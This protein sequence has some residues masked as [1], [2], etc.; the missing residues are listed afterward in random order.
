MLEQNE[1]EENTKD[2]TKKISFLDTFK[3]NLIDLIVTAIISV[4]ALFVFDLLLRILFGYYVKEIVPMLFIF[5]VVVSL[6]ST[7]IAEYKKAQTIGKK[8]ANL[9]ISKIV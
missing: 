5:Y 4:A 3:A 9:K 1:F 6:V 8:V 7:S 2:I